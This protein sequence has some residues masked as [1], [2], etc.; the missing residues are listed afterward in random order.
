MH[1]QHLSVTR[2]EVTNAMASGDGV[3]VCSSCFAFFLRGW[4]AGG[5]GLGGRFVVSE[6]K[7]FTCLK[8]EGD[9]VAWW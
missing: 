2:K 3:K 7:C 5:R 6:T 9:G 8:R 4:R 1:H